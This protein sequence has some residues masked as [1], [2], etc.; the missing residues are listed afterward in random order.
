MDLWLVTDTAYFAR[1]DPAIPLQR[2]C[3]L[4]GCASYGL[5][6]VV[7]MAGSASTTS[8]TLATILLG[9]SSGSPLISRFSHG[10][11]FSS[12][13]VV[14][15]WP[16]TQCLLSIHCDGELLGI[17]GAFLVLECAIGN[18]VHFVLAV[19]LVQIL[20]KRFMCC[21]GFLY[22]QKS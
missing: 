11:G 4:P 9:D 2:C 14:H 16:S 21:F 12:C 10:L 1:C 6:A 8:P 13:C 15:I 5:H 3:C 17:C 7:G 18:V 22:V 20:W 19:Y